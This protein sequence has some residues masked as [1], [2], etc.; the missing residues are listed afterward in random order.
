MFIYVCIYI[1]IILP[2][3]AQKM[4]AY[5]FPVNV[6][7]HEDKMDLSVLLCPSGMHIHIYTYVY[8]YV[9]FFIL[10]FIIFTIF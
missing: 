3:E 10:C 7:P 1:A 2:Q 4:D 8:V 5:K 9:E 6:N